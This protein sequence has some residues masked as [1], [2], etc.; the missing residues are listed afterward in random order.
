MTGPSAWVHNT[1][2][3]QEPGQAPLG[4]RPKVSPHFQVVSPSL[5]RGLT[6]TPHRERV[7]TGEGVCFIICSLW[8]L[9]LK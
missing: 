3:P 1:P 7:M 8:D 2:R 4:G 9:C 5:S 6:S